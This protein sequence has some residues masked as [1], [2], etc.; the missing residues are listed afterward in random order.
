[1]SSI[2]AQYLEATKKCPTYSAC[3]GCTTTR[4]NPS[5]F[6]KCYE[7]PFACMEKEAN[8]F[9]VMKEKPFSDKQMQRIKEKIRGKAGTAFVKE[10]GEEGAIEFVEKTELFCNQPNRDQSA[11]RWCNETLKTLD[12]IDNSGRTL[13]LDEA[14][15]MM[16]A[17]DAILERE[18]Q[19]A[20][21]RAENEKK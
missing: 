3:T 19:I 14:R 15:T 21:V 16:N 9:L 12:V 17:Y 2:E 18:K 8:G 5:L 13:G 6:D 7:D 20:A 11:S 1:M 4:P 10:Y